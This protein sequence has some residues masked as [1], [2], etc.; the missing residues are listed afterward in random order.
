MSLIAKHV[1]S[2]PFK[3]ETPYVREFV[4]TNRVVRCFPSQDKSAAARKHT[5]LV[6]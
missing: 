4:R 1:H 2:F 5:S 6:C 3:S